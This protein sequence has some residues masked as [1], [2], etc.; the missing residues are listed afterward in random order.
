MA[1]GP[2]YT[3]HSSFCRCSGLV[4]HILGDV[5]FLW[6]CN[7]LAHFINT[8]AVDDNVSGSTLRVEGL[9]GARTKHLQLEGING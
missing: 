8:Y 1:L 7:L 2:F 3:S 6:C 4:P 5:I 9:G